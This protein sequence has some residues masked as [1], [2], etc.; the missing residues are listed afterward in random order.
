MKTLSEFYNEVARK[1]DTGKTGISVA[2]TKR[3]LAIAFEV[4]ENQ[5]AAQASDLIA[6]GLCQANKK[7]CAQ[8]GKKK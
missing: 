1:T 6:K 2:E 8:S 5:P 3:V 4:L 7:R